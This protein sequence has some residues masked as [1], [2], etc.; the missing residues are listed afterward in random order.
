MKKQEVAVPGIRKR[1][2]KGWASGEGKWR[3]WLGLRLESAGQRGGPGSDC[4]EPRILRGSEGR[5]EDSRTPTRR[6]TDQVT[7]S[8]EGGRKGT[9]QGALWMPSGG[10]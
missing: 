9:G 2:G 10:C 7:L 4:R 1:M 5:Q 8:G 6:D 3:L